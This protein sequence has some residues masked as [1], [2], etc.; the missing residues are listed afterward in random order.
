[1]I[2]KTI[3]SETAVE[4]LT[5]AFNVNFNIPASDSKVGNSFLLSCRTQNT[6][7]DIPPKA[8]PRLSQFLFLFEPLEDAIN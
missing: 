5:L 1:M 2:V 8:S 7:G 4:P 6:H 3:I